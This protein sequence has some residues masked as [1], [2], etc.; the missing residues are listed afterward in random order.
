MI[1]IKLSTISAGEYKYTPVKHAKSFGKN[2]DDSM[3]W[4]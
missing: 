1:L 2:S 4:L 3:N